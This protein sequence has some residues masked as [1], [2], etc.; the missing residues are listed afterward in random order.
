MNEKGFGGQRWTG[1][2]VGLRCFVYS[3]LHFETKPQMRQQTGSSVF[4][5][6]KCPMLMLGDEKL[7]AQMKAFSWK[8]NLCSSPDATLNKVSLA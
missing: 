7:A 3:E 6:A 8:L 5:T 2:Q 4:L 1:D